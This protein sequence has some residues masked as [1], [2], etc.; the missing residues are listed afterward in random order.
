MG[1][2]DRKSRRN[3]RYGR[4]ITIRSA[5]DGEEDC[6]EEADLPEKATE[7]DRSPTYSDLAHVPSPH[8][9][10]FGDEVADTSGGKKS[11]KEILW[12]EASSPTAGNY[13]EQLRA[14]GQRALQRAK[15]GGFVPRLGSTVP[16]PPAVAPSSSH[17][18]GGEMII[19]DM[20]VSQEQYIALC[21]T[22][23][24]SP[25]S[26]AQALSPTWAA[27]STAPSCFFPEAG[28][29][30]PQSPMLA[31]PV[32]AM[33]MPEC[34]QAAQMVPLPHLCSMPLTPTGEDLMMIAMPQ[35]ASCDMNDEQ[36]AAHLRA[37][38][39]MQYED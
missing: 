29:D 28:L 34:P 8:R 15:E 9:R 36:I 37:A 33:P 7:S 3:V 18:A 10:R 39:P 24:P 16:P 23:A 31:Q 13:R 32:A 20:M 4:D 5:D 17:T 25:V 26:L 12:L 1:A 35:A 6:L 2:G 38:A 21:C 27:S 30:M 14:N 19:N 22:G 11:P